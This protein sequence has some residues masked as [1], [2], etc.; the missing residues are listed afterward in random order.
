M[1]LTEAKFVIDAI[2]YWLKVYCLMPSLEWSLVES[3]I[4]LSDRLS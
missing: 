4:S 3:L 2:R 1:K